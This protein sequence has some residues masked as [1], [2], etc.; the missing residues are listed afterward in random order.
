VGWGTGVLARPRRPGGLALHP[1]GDGVPQVSPV[2][3]DAVPPGVL[4]AAHVGHAGRDE[5]AIARLGPGL[6]LG[7]VIPSASRLAVQVGNDI[8]HL[9]R[10]DRLLRNVVRVLHRPRVV[11]AVRKEDRGL[12]VAVRCFGIPTFVL[13]SGV[14]LGAGRVEPQV[15][16][17]VGPLEH[18]AEL[19]L[20]L[21]VR[22]VAED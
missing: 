5:G 21:E 6:G 15:H 17:F 13:L 4:Q 7:D 3:D 19:V 9:V 12:D 22:P 18:L 8:V 10:A 11:D 1:K 14:I 2:D 20:A 16:G